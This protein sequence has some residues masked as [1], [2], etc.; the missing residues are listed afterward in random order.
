MF[1]YHTYIQIIWEELV[2]F[3]MQPLSWQRSIWS[4]P[5]PK[6]KDLIFKEF[7]QLLLRKNLTII[8]ADQQDST[9]PLSS[10]LW[11]FFGDGSI[12]VA[13]VD[14]HARG[15]A[16]LYFPDLNL[17]IAADLCWGIDLLPYT[18]QMHLIPSFVQ[19]NKSD[20]IRGQVLEE[21]LKDGI[22]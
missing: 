16:C 18:K 12:L 15:Q 2:S 9:F 13:S 8:R 4:L 6:L 1:F 11:S 3:L 20:Y 22:R 7:Y 17:L 5:K 14:G 19:D 21:V 10:D